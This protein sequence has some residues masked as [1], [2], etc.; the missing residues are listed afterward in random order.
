MSAQVVL[1]GLGKHIEVNGGAQRLSQTCP[2]E[3]HY[4]QALW[5]D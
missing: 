5:D 3:G 2:G 4:G 1:E